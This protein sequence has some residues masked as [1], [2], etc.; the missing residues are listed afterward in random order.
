MVSVVPAG[1]DPRD[2]GAVPPKKSRGADDADDVLRAG[3]VV[4]EM[5]AAMA[6]EVARSIARLKLSAL[7]VL[8]RA[9]D[10][11]RLSR[12]GR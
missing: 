11:K 5:L 8:G 7:A 10:R 1:L 4:G 3:G 12:T 9:G 2:H 6:G